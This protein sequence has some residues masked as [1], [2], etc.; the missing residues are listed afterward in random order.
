[1]SQNLIAA[2][3]IGSQQ[4]SAVVGR[5]EPD[6]AINVIAAEQEPSAKFIQRG[7]VFNPDL[8]SQ[9]V[10]GM[11]GKLEATSHKAINKVYVGV[12]GIGLHTVLNKVVRNFAE[13]TKVTQ[14]IVDSILDENRSCKIP[15]FSIID[16]QTLEYKLQTQSLADPVGVMSNRI[17]GNFLNII[18]PSVSLEQ[19]DISFQA[20]KLPIAETI[21][22]PIQLA[23]TI[24]TDAE[25]LSGCG[26]IDM[27]AQ[28]TTIGIFE[29][30]LLRYL[31]VLPLGGDNVTRDLM[32]VLSIEQQE[33]EDIKRRHGAAFIEAVES[34]PVA[35]DD[36]RLQD[37]RSVPYDKVVDIIE[38]RMAEILLNVAHIIK[39]EAGYTPDRLIGGLVVTGG[40]SNM[41]AVDKAL[42]EYTHIRKLRFVKNAPLTI[43]R[44]KPSNFNID[45]TFNGV[46][47][48]VANATEECCSDERQNPDIFSEPQQPTPEELEQQRLEQERQEQERL[49]KER[50]EQER[51]K[52]EEKERH[53]NRF[54]SLKRVLKNG[55]DNLGKVF[56]E[57]SDDEED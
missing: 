23:N 38:S 14:D 45:G 15:D 39:V 24:L 8:M 48:I 16:V 6:G 3:E 22:S 21:V 10:K 27:G 4:V 31:A 26:F 52:Q 53:R 25:K 44:S 19:L 56:T 42:I 57:P 49:E 13:T 5:K 43:R 34:S 28:S 12:G 47:S 36:I 29:G 18:V 35:H 1:M 7:R 20:A 17:E 30:K 37:G 11:I 33:A 54:G 41:S 46:L 50:Q 55:L 40:A 51:L 32:T 9:C 2:I